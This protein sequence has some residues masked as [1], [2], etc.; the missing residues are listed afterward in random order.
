[1][2]MTT[3]GITTTDNQAGAHSSTLVC[4][5]RNIFT[6]ALSVPPSPPLEERAGERRLS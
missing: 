1:M 2:G 5:N 4:C 6:D 3:G